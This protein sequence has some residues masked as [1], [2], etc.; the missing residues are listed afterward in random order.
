VYAFNAQIKK[1]GTGF[2]GHNKDVSRVLLQELERFSV[3]TL[4]LTLAFD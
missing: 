1:S 4:L 2:Q 3:F